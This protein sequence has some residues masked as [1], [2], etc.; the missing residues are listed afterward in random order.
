[1][2][3]CVLLSTPTVLTFAGVIY[4][5]S[6]SN[7]QDGY[8]SG[9]YHRGASKRGLDGGSKN[10]GESGNRGEF[11][12]IQEGNI[13]GIRDVHMRTKFLNTNGL[14]LV[15]EPVAHCSNP[16]TNTSPSSVYLMQ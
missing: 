5:S 3:V 10:R 12:E 9:I 2:C 6:S 4:G 8:T 11:C 13:K 7:V 1:M 16:N 15:A 14:V